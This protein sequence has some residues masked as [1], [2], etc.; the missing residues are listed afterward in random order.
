[1]LTR[2]RSRRSGYA[3]AALLL[4][5]P[6][7]AAA[8]PDAQLLAD[9]AWVLV[10]AA[11]V[12]LMQAGFLC[13][14]VG[15]VQPKAA[16]ITALKNVVDWVICVVASFAFGWALMF[17]HTRGGLMGGDF[18]FLSGDT[19]GGHPIGLTIHHLFQVAFAGTAA[20][21]VSGALAERTGF[22]AY[23]VCSA[24][25]TALIYPIIGHWAWGNSFFAD[26]ETFLTRLGFIDFAGSTVVH[27]VG[28]W[29]SLVGIR[30][31]GARIGWIGKGGKVVE[32]PGTGMQWTAF[33]VLLLWFSWWGFNGGSTLALND[34]VG[35]IIIVTNLSATC[36][37]L[38]ALLYAWSTNQR[39]GISTKFLNGI[40]GGLVGITA[41]CANTTP[42]FACAVGVTSGVV[43]VVVANLLVRMRLDDPVGAVP[44]HLGCGT[45]GTLCVGLFGDASTFPNHATRLH[46]IGAQLAGIAACAAWCLPVAWLTFT[47]LRKWVGL[48]VSPREETE[49]Y[50]IGGVRQVAEVPAMSEEQLRALLGGK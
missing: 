19:T 24:V 36:G 7:T 33:G 16:V 1:M 22:R 10:A 8:A 40:L 46:Q 12:F 41:G 50:D 26:N 45:W 23:M 43:T 34:Q 27:S 39:E 14:E 13:L 35:T 18:W 42:L 30:A 29:V 9:R 25:V 47:A 6:S 20:T 21:I 11:M 3:V 5:L 48:R 32:L 17:G 38:G 37:G 15:C 31:V 2:H 49:G 44:V 28:G 4:L